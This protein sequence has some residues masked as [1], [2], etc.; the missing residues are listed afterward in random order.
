MM[1]NNS[2][3]DKEELA[4]WYADAR[5]CFW[6]E[7]A[8]WEDLRKIKATNFNY[9][10]SW[11]HIVGRRGEFA[12]SLLNSFFINNDICHLPNH[13]L[14]RK[15]SNKIKLLKKTLE[16]LLYKGYRFT[17]KDIGFI[18]ANGD[19]YKEVLKLKKNENRRR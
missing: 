6:C 19:L 9:G 12:S 18:M 16:W 14:L 15:R 17:E 7:I 1:V 13:P 8:D 5:T 11:H 4:R 2:D 10:D 3:F